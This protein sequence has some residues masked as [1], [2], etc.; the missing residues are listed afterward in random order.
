MATRIPRSQDDGPSRPKQL[1]GRVARTNYRKLGRSGVKVSPL[2]L[3]AM[4]FGGPTDEPTAV[5]IIAPA[6]EAGINFIATSDVSNE[7]RSEEIAGGAWR[8]DP[9]AWVWGP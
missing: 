7:G 2:C 6:A 5:R 8:R 3:G 4:M 1:N 9:A